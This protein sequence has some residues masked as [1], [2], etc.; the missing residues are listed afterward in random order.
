[1][2][3]SPGSTSVTVTFILVDDSGLP[4]TG[5]VAA[6]LPPINYTRTREAAVAITL[7]DLAL[8]TSAWASGGVKEIGGGRYRLDLP[9]AA[10]ATA[11]AELEVYGEASGLHIIPERHSV[12]DVTVGGFAS[13]ALTALE[14][15]DITYSAPTLSQGVI[16]PPIIRHRDYSSVENNAIDIVITGG[17][18]FSGGTTYLTAIDKGRSNEAFRWDGTILNAGT[19][20]QTLRFQ[21]TAAQTAHPAA[22]YEAQ[23]VVVLPS[24]RKIS[25]AR[26]FD[27]PLVG[28]DDAVTP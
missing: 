6:T 11:T 26:I 27:L 16:N 19:A 24:G 15:L 1:M 9:N 2:Q 12:G 4:V 3:I 25:P 7:A 13:A 21:P 17:A 8:I 10:V 20:T 23:A 22:T 28:K 14:G 18:D 5:K